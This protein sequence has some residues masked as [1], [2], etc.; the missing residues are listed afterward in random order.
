MI[1]GR[2]LQID[3]PN[4]VYEHPT[5]N[6]SLISWAPPTSSKGYCEMRSR[7]AVVEIVETD[8]GPLQCSFASPLASGSRVTISVPPEE[9]KN[10]Q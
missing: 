6:S 10:R 9:H 3:N 8:L 1:A 2:I 4:E 7:A 5:A